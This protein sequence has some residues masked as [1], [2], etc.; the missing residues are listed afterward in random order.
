ML[1]F[2]MLPQFLVFLVDAT[3][4]KKVQQAELQATVQATVQANHVNWKYRF[5]IGHTVVLRL[6][7][8][9]FNLASLAKYRKFEEVDPKFLFCGFFLCLSPL[10]R[11]NI[12]VA[13]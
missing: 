4:Y 12:C 9:F 5:S 13:E 7:I 3:A 11:G 2:A 1:R 6:G 10:G 8:P